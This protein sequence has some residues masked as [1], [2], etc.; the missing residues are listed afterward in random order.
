VTLGWGNYGKYAPLAFTEHGAVMAASVLNSPNAVEMSVFVVRAFL[1]LRPLV[2]G[3]KE[4]AA[5]PSCSSG[6]GW[7]IV[8]MQFPFKWGL[9]GAF[10]LVQRGAP[11][12]LHRSGPARD[13]YVWACEL[14]TSQYIIIR[15]SLPSPTLTPFAMFWF[16]PSGGDHCKPSPAERIVR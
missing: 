3:Q 13:L 11:L 8:E 16:N 15:D 9:I 5:Q 12:V 1:R 14:S 4:L 7:G 2:A 6:T 10:R